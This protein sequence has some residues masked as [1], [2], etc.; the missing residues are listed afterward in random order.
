MGRGI[1]QT[2]DFHFVD[3]EFQTKN[4]KL[5]IISGLNLSLQK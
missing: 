2:K 4:V 3:S 5:F 1:Q